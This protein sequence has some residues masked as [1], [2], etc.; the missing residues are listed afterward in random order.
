MR[1]C[2][3]LVMQLVVRAAAAA[4]AFLLTLAP[5][6]SA[7]AADPLELYALIR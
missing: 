2:Q 4:L 7:R 5:F 6:G 1:I 3:G